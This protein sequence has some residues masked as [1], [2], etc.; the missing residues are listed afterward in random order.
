MVEAAAARTWESRRVAAANSRESWE[1]TA[2]ALVHLLR[3]GP[4]FDLWTCVVRN[5]S[6]I[7]VATAVH[8][9]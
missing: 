6:L 1:R 8:T 2:D 3:M 4:G 5:C 9:V 7:W